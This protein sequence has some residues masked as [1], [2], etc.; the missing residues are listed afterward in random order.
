M[1]TTKPDLPVSFSRIYKSA[2]EIH[3]LEREIYKWKRE[4]RISLEEIH[5]WAREI[6]ISLAHLCIVSQG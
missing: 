3:I 4:I 1:S 2:K 5:K 6:H